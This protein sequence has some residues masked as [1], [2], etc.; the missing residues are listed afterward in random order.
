MNIDFTEDEFQGKKILHVIDSD[1]ANHDCGIIEFHTN[2]G[3]VYQAGYD[4]VTF[5]RKNLLELAI[6]II[7]LE[8]KA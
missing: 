3:Y 1:D 5:T 7:K 4:S 6:E 8:K 2:E